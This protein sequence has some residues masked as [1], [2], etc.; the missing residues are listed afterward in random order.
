MTDPLDSI[1]DPREKR[2]IA[3]CI[4]YVNNDPAGIPGHNILLIVAKLAKLLANATPEMIKHM[5]EGY[6]ES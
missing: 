2:L 5:V 3:N 6:D 4:A 1:F